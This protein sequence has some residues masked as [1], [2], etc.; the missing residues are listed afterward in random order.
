MTRTLLILPVLLLMACKAKPRDNPAGSDTGSAARTGDGSA[1]VADQITSG[2]SSIVGAAVDGAGDRVWLYGGG[3][4][5]FAFTRSGERSA[6][7]EAPGERADDVDVEFTSDT[8]TVGTTTFPRGSLVFINGESGP[9]EI[10][11]VDPATG[12]VFATLQTQFG[13]SHVVG[14][15]WHPGR[16]TFFL[17][18]DNQ[19]AGDEA[20]RIA[21]IDPATG[22]ILRGFTLGARFSV[23]YGDLDVHGPSGNLVVVSSS[24]SRLAE[25]TPAGELVRYIALPEGVSSLSGIG[26]DDG[27]GEA[28]VSGTGG[29]VWRL[30]GFGR[31]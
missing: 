26:L 6:A 28:W 7:I 10:Y 2:M 4:S 30:R 17:L 29:A 12:A 3:D 27:R 22:R 25:F 19:P 15:A 24:E 23:H 31:P 13:A 11:A 20:N 1:A 21:E 16:R 14:G 5:L 8:V 9:A 18:Q